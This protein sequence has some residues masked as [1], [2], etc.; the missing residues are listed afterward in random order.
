MRLRRLLWIVPAL[1]AGGC[2][3]AEL[4]KP[5]DSS[6]RLCQVEITFDLGGEAFTNAPNNTEDETALRTFI[7]DGRMLPQSEPPRILL[8]SNNWQQVNDVRIYVFRKDDNGRFTYYRPLTESG[9]RQEYLSVD[10]FRLKFDRSPWIVWW[11]GPDDRNESH[12]FVGRL[13]LETGEYRFLA[14]ARDDRNV[15][16]PILADPNVANPDIAGTDGG[17]TPWSEGVTTLDEATLA[18]SDINPVVASTELFAGCTSETLTVDGSSHSFFRSILLERAVAGILLYVEDIPATLKAYD[19]D[20]EVPTGII[21][22]QYEYRVVSLAVAHGTI[23]SD[24]V[25]IADREA[26]DGRLSVP[27]YNFAFNPPTPDHVLLKIDIPEQATVRNGFYENTS[28]DNERHPNSLCTGSFVMPQR[29]NTPSPSQAETY[30]KSLYLVFYGRG[31]YSGEEF[32]LAWMPIR[33]ESGAGY[34]PLYYPILPN[35]F[36]SIGRRLFA[37]DGSNLPDEEDVP[38]NL[39]KGTS[40]EIVIRLDPFWNEYYGGEIGDAEP[41]LGLDPDWG[42]HPAG[43]LQQ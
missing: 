15:G 7:P 11:G 8:S 41:G 31:L 5:D 29:A 34:D 9:S 30:D 40:E 25:R 1:I 2:S 37:G 13:Q 27:R 18:C 10:D 6:P 21:P 39:R 19:P 24:Q 42:D 43:N 35:H 36:Y 28:P 38:I 33:L 3:E 17:W 4:P 20:E 14:L 12:R 26:M 32:A 16:K 23:L 22:S